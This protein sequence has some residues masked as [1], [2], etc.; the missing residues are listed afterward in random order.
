MVSKLFQTS[1]EFRNPYVWFIVVISS[2]VLAGCGRHN[3]GDQ[4][5]N[6]T[7]QKFQQYYFQGEKLYAKHCSNCHQLNGKGLGRVYPPLD[8]SDFIHHNFE[9][10]VCLI[11]NG[12]TGELIV[13]GKNFNQTMKG[14]SELTN[15]EVAEIT[16]YLYN[17]WGRHRGLTDETEAGRILN[18]CPTVQQDQ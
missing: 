2:F 9:A 13:N 7:D 5:S 3:T 6:T 8:S 10:V 4:N 14:I 1:L 12:K 18:T 16:T 15:L 11:R 17:T